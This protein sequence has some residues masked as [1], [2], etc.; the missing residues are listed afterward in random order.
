MYK[1]LFVICLILGM[2]GCDQGVKVK[3][4]PEHSY[5]LYD[6]EQNIENRWYCNHDG[7][8]ELSHQCNGF[9]DEELCT[10]DDVITH[11][12]QC[13]P[14]DKPK[15]E[16]IHD[17]NV[18]FVCEDNKWLPLLCNPGESCVDGICVPTDSVCE[19]G[20]KQCNWVD[21]IESAVEMRC[22][23]DVWLSKVCARGMVCSDEGTCIDERICIPGSEQCRFDEIGNGMLYQCIDDAWV[24]AG[25]IGPCVST[26]C[27]DGYYLEHGYCYKKCEEGKRECLWDEVH[28]QA[29]IR[30]CIDGKWNV[31]ECIHG[32]VCSEDNL[33]VDNHVC[34]ERDIYCEYDEVGN[35]VMYTC[36]DNA[37]IT[38]G[39]SGEC[40][41]NC[42]EGYVLEDNQCVPRVCS[43]YDIYCEY[44]EVGNAVM[45]TCK[46]N[47]WIT[48]GTS[49]ECI[50]NC[51]EGYVLEDNQCVPIPVCIEHDFYCEYD[52]V[53]NSVMY[54]CKDNAWMTDGSSGICV[55]NCIEGYVLEGGK[56]VQEYQLYEFEYT[57]KVQSIT[58]KPG[59]YRLRVYGAQGASHDMYKGGMGAVVSGD[60]TL[61]KTTNLYIYVGGMGMT[62]GKGGWNGGGT[63]YMQ[64]DRA[65][66]SAGGGG[67]S[68]IALSGHTGSAEWNHQEHLCSRLIVAG[69]GGGGLYY[70]GAGADGGHGGAWMGTHGGNDDPG[71]GGKLDAAGDPAPLW[72]VYPSNRDGIVLPGFG[73][74]GGARWNGEPM[75]GGGGGWYGGSAGTWLNHNGSGG[76]GSSYA[77]TKN[78]TYNGKS[79]DAYYPSQCTKPD[80]PFLLKNVT[81]FSGEQ[82]GN[83]KIIIETI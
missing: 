46:N 3:C 22:E 82:T 79:L 35:A 30:E 75:G 42:I 60:L 39:T 32:H 8:W 17:L 27:A 83:G 59:T 1:R 25:Y 20:A 73:F 38:D 26:S 45:Y 41:P 10:H 49:G 6:S 19:E 24:A 33:C 18:L 47:A 52:E 51:I 23:S 57:G 36:K 72:D 71:Q 74:G 66:A 12:P 67:A 81:V 29:T 54:I 61:K 14:D 48:D 21:E 56:C 16:N 80:T 78:T 68:D 65:D 53:G 69:G 44:D 37:W 28:E 13:G 4:I 5:C 77:Y 9:C 55:P 11:E 40:I 43:E 2:T 34:T 63:V 58:L 15:C 64:S 50:P 31:K 76:G 7:E 62:D 70:L